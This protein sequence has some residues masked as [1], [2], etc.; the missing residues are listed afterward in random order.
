VLAQAAI[1]AAQRQQQTHA[2]TGR[3]C[4]HPGLQSRR[5]RAAFGRRCAQIDQMAADE[6]VR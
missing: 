4:Q 3:Q 1:A 6:L 5:I 2:A